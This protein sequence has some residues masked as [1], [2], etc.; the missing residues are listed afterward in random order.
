MINFNRV[1]AMILRDLINLRH[2]FDRIG[3]MF[4]WPAM[5]LFIWGLTGLY[6][7]QQN[8]NSPYAIQIILTG[9]IFWIVIWR[10]QYEISINLLSEMWDR[11]LVNIFASPLTIKEWMTSVLIF[12]FIKMFAS[13]A[14]S[15][16]LAFI[17]Y[18]FN[19]FVYGILL[20]PFLVSLLLTGWFT[21]FLVAGIIIKYGQK[22]QTLAWTGVAL[23]AP[24][25]ALYYP[26]SVLPDWAQKISLFI[27]S[28]YVLEGMR[29][30]LL[31]KPFSYDKLLISFGLNIMYLIFS[32]WFFIFMF[33]KS[34]KLGLGR[35]I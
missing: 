30:I 12:G 20:V 1:Y 4:Y 22:L 13:F 34:R 31:Q 15:A 29:E 14:F 25:T 16:T 9:L 32:I 24:F 28:S 10:A 35:L 5:D 18:K 17:L 7:I 33:K 26:V 23:I 8:V 27:P 19:V 21:G 3:D 11:N 6:I 2:N